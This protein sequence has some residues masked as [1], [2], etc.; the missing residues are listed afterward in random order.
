MVNPYFLGREVDSIVADGSTIGFLYAPLYGS[1][2]RPGDN[3]GERQRL[4][5][6]KS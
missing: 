6:V 4:A 2:T 5:D 3:G 1:I